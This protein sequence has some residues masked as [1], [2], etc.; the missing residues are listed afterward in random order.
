M[1]KESIGKRITRCFIVILLLS[2]ASTGA[3][4][5][6]HTYTQNVRE[7]RR[8]AERCAEIVRLSLDR[9]ELDMEALLSAEADERY[10]SE[11][12]S[13]RTLCR[14]FDLDYLYI[15]TVDPSAGERRFLF[16]VGGDDD[17][18]AV[19]L[20]E[21]YLGAVSDE[22]FD[23]W[24]QALLSGS[25]EMQMGRV[26]TRYGNNV[27]WLSPY[28]DGQGRLLVVIGMDQS[29]RLEET[30]VLREFLVAV[31]PV[32]LAL[33]TGLLVLLILMRRRI[34]RPI[35]TLSE[36]MSL[37][38]ADSSREPEPIGIRSEDE[39]GEIAASYEKM[40]GDIRAYIA[41]IESLTR[42]RV[43]TNVQLD[44]ARRIQYGLVPEETSLKGE[45]FALHAVTRPA[46]AVGGDFYDCFTGDG[47]TVCAV[48]GDVS[49]KGISA[50][51]FMAMAKTVI[52]EKLTSG[53]GPAE[54]LNQVNDVF[55]AQNPEG[56]FATVFVLVFDPE[57]GRMRYANAGHTPPVLL[58]SPCRLLRPDSGI[59]LGLFEGAGI[60]EDELTV[61]PGEGILLYTDGVTEA[62][63]L[64]KKFFGEAR[65]LGALEGFSASSGTAEDAV[66]TVTEAVERFREE[67][68][69]FDDMA[70]LSLLR[71]G[72]GL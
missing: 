25:R 30:K 23:K 18:D 26:S 39:I 6:Y 11:R 3:W 49:G 51:I 60:V 4:N 16:C 9:A 17:K 48:L 72:R 15:Y 24:E 34:L 35:H 5:Y 22:A 59:A 44:V 13:L 50:A 12:D 20:R 42:E 2:L 58:G 52:H 19:V 54:T 37:F 65:L 47:N 45:G 55:C 28:T 46:R 53:F 36:R 56:L 57:S 38:A 32:V 67:N 29:I 70:V 43:E 27:T 10:R 68:E 21:R 62:V 14:T 64:Q 1:K 7:S 71:T 41:N 8:E 31:L 63:N 66:R 69:A 61:R 33:T 40:T